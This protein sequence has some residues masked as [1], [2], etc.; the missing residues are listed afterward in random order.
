MS[1]YGE[2]RKKVAE[3]EAYKNKLLHLCL[4]VS[5]YINKNTKY[6]CMDCTWSHFGVHTKIKYNSNV[7]FTIPWNNFTK[8]D[9]MQFIEEKLR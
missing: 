9:W 5:K 2:Y 3:V 6:E 4:R 8:N 7:K 1:V